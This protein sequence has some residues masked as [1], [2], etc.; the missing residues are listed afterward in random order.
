MLDMVDDEMLFYD[1]DAK[2]E[3][4]R[5]YLPHWSQAGRVCFVTFRLADSIP[6]ARAAEL[7]RERQA[8]CQA[9]PE[10]YTPAQWREYHTL[11]SARVEQWLDQC[12]G[13]CVLGDPLCAQVVADAMDVFEGRRYRLD[14][15]VIMPNHVHVLVTPSGRF[16]LEAV[17][18]GWKS[19]TSHAIN[20]LL[21]R[22]GRLWQ[23]E[24]FDHIVRSAAHLERFRQYIRDNPAKAGRFRHL[25]RLRSS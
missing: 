5:R 8:W 24:S 22:H 10:P 20:R 11:F 23:G 19:F 18:Q 12:S 4:Y 7:R 14:Q 6:A 13:S 9:H 25:C 15:W 1:P 2:K 21:G 3:V 17:L 16:T